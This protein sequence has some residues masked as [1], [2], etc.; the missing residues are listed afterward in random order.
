MN[1]FLS[2]YLCGY[3][4]GYS[5]QYAL[6]LLIERWKKMLDSKGFAGAMLMDLSK[7]FD[8]LNHE[9]LIAKLDAYG[10]DKKALKLVHSYLSNRWQRTKINNS[11]SSW[12]ELILGVPQGSVLGPILFNIY[13]N[14]LFWINSFT[15][16]CNFADDTTFYACDKSLESVLQSLEHDSLL[17]I[18]WFDNNYMK[19]NSDKCHLLISG[20]KH[21]WHWAQ[22]GD[23]KIW[24]S[25]QEKLLGVTIDKNL[26][27]ESHVSKICL[28]ANRKL[29][30]LARVSRM[31]PLHKRKI[32]F[33]AFVKSQFAYCP[34]IWM[35][36]DRQ[37]N[38]KINR[39]HERALRIVYQDDISTFDELLTKDEGF[40]IHERNV[41][42]LAIEVYKS[43]CG[44]SPDFM[45]E[46]FLKKEYGRINMRNNS[47]YIV[48]RTNTV[49]NGDDS[50]RHLGPLIWN[51]V[52][53]YIKCKSSLIAFKKAIK[54]WR[55]CACPC[56]L[57][58]PYIQGVGY[59]NIA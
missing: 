1:H 32:L 54:K 34:L 45:N 41:Q 8:T 4:K 6:I 55:P 37:I 27:F 47:E 5:T 18:E 59:L 12:A 13:I 40:T 44:L 19:L 2:P 56:R 58:K 26:D 35:F 33:N 43:K 11:F 17:A 24:E 25:R 23:Y 21:Q 49:H 16:V 22:L 15:E 53:D 9:L 20:F 48:P 7:A 42:L 50:L 46:L 29:S 3:R 10:F 51:I 30:A 39:L 52:P 36:H 28:N 31:M 57:C 38:A 14:D